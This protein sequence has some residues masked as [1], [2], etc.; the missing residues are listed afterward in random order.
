[1]KIKNFFGGIAI[2]AVAAVAALNVNMTAKIGNVSDL[3]LAEVEALAQQEGGLKV[4]QIGKVIVGLENAGFN[5]GNEAN[6]MIFGDYGYNRVGSK[7]SFGDFNTWN[8]SGW[9]VF[10][11]E[12]SNYDDTDQLWLH[13][14][15]GV[16]LTI[17]GRADQV[18]AKYDVDNGNRFDFYCPVYAQSVQLTSDARMKKDVDAIENPLASLLQL[19]GVSYHWDAEQLLKRSYRNDSVKTKSAKDI[20]EIELADKAFFEQRNDSVKKNLPER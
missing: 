13:G 12:Y 1:M 17:G 16:Y 11:G 3:S 15:R 4:N 20:N 18:I 9:H 19:N 7:M 6:L 2:V 10:V 8:N 14:R 5:S